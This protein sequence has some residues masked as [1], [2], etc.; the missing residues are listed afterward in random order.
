MAYRICCGLA[1]IKEV[2][3]RSQAPLPRP[4]REQCQTTCG[5]GSR[6]AGPERFGSRP[7]CQQGKDRHDVSSTSTWHA[8]PCC[9]CLVCNT[10]HVLPHGWQGIEPSRSKGQPLP[11]GPQVAEPPPVEATTPGCEVPAIPRPIATANRGLACRAHSASGSRSW[12]P[13]W[14]RRVRS[15]KLAVHAHLQ[16][17]IFPN[18]SVPFTTSVLP[19]RLQCRRTRLNAVISESL[20]RFPHEL[21]ASLCPQLLR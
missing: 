19:R 21:L 6:P 16:E 11:P 7:Q 12:K 15:G 17:H 18:P 10:Q 4:S 1:K 14:R 5:S 2:L 8:E 3:C 13:L 20:R 9:R